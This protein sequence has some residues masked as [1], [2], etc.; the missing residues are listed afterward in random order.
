M[1][2]RSAETMMQS[3]QT[4]IING[5]KY[6]FQPGETILEV[7]R[8]NEVYIPTLCHLKGAPPTGACRMCVVEVKGAPGPIAAC[9]SPAADNM[10]V[11]TETPRIVRARKMVL[12]LLLISGNH[13]CSVRGSTPREWSDFQQD[14]SEYDKAGDICIAYGSCELQALAYR[15]QVT[16]KK[17][18]RIPT[19]YPLEYDDPLIGRDF[20]R[21]I[22][23]GRCV[24]A[25][26][27]IQV[28]NAISHG[29]RGNLAKIVVKGDLTLPFSDCVYCGECVQSCPVG[30]LFEKRNRFNYRMWNVKKVR[31]TCHYCGVGCQL[32]LFIKGGK[33]VKVDGTEDVKPNQGRLCFKGRFGFDFIHSRERLTK[34][35]IRDKGKLVETSWESALDWMTVKLKEMKKKYGP[36]AIGCLVS[37]KEK[38]ED[39]FQIK[40]FFKEVSNP[41]NV[42]HF[43]SPGF[44]KVDYADLN[45]VKTI[46]AV[47][48]D[49]TRENPVAATFV[50]QA[51]LNGAKL[52]AVDMKN[53]EMAKFAHVHLEDLSEIETEI[54]GDA[55]LFHDPDVDVSGLRNLKS[56]TIHSIS[57]E[58][59][60]LGAYLL[61]I[62]PGN[63]L[64]LKKL[65]F[66]Y[67][68]SPHGIN[69]DSLELL[70]VQ[71]IFPS[72]IMEKADLVLPAS[73]WVEHEGTTVSSDLRINLVQK[74]LEAPGL[75]K[76]TGWIFNELARRMDL[77]WDFSSN[78]ELWEQYMGSEIPCFRNVT[79]DMLM[80]EGGR[81][82]QETEIAWERA[83]RVPTGFKRRNC[84]RV[85]AEHCSDLQDVVKK[86]F[87]EAD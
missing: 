61:G 7:A 9:S 8:R 71:D 32:D 68:M 63:D 72:E 50:K 73:V 39:L 85:L 12:E 22:L 28:N 38:N 66:L 24:Q 30:A 83:V 37:T 40:K 43:E 45:K 51:V 14:V 65:K 67:S 53:T 84:Q 18:D 44:L 36:E 52:I 1:K 11:F 41:E 4:I 82:I 27:E 21:C 13:N 6:R 5:N 60:T 70:V 76:P 59:N 26:C 64:N 77:K 34:P 29:Y 87:K 33:I 81:T 17:L 47:A 35:M 31:T 2:K 80:K 16:Q 58:N 15:Y 25:C 46:V 54:E 62:F 49:M 10:E 20:G 42:F 69:T 48:T 55:I 86:R 57:K 74:V 78:R 19:K 23:C 56:I 3:E 79:Y 75:A